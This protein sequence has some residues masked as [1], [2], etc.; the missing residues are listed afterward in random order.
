MKKP[1]FLFTPDLED[2][3]ANERGLYHDFAQ[4]PFPIGKTNDELCKI[5][6][7]FNC[8]LYQNKIHSFMLE[9]NYILDG[10]A[11]KKIYEIILQYSK[12]ESH[13]NTIRY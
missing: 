5:I 7:S 13:L 10:Q 3:I 9:Q 8:Q 4:L 1:V 6:E 11:S 2:Y 12:N